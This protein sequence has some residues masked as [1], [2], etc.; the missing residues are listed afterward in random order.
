L[1]CVQGYWKSDWSKRRWGYIEEIIKKD[2]LGLD[3]IYIQAKRW[4]NVVGSKEVR[5]FVGSLASQKANK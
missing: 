1:R 5:T 4:E 2:K 3:I